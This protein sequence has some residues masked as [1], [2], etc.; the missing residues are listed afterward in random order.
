MYDVTNYGEVP[1]RTLRTLIMYAQDGVPTGGFTNA[2]LINDLRGAVGR[3]DK[4][5]LKALKL[6]VEFICNQLPQLCHGSP[7][8]VE[9]WLATVREGKEN[10]YA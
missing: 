10:N 3:A 5:N 8:K 7:K 6:I 1:E 9:T 4:G 2:V